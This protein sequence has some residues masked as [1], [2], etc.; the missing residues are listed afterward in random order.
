MA[1]RTIIPKKA[2]KIEGVTLTPALAL[3][4]LD[5]AKGARP[6]RAA[7]SELRILQSLRARNLIR[8]NR[9]RWPTHTITT[10]RGREVLAALLARQADA[11]AEHDIE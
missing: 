10:T 4:L 8:F 7:I 9:P 2:F 11:L 5:H 3:T 6:T 1:S